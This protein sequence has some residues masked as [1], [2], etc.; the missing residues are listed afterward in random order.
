[1][2]A[3]EFLEGEG[4]ENIILIAAYDSL[5][6]D[7]WKV[8]HLISSS[9]VQHVHSRTCSNILFS[10][11]WLFL[12]L[13]NLGIQSQNP[14]LQQNNFPTCVSLQICNA[15]LCIFENGWVIRI[16]VKNR[17]ILTFMYDSSTGAKWRIIQF[18]IWLLFHMTG[19]QFQHFMAAIFQIVYYAR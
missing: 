17:C 6:S 1:M 18:R 15:V 3:A 4:W 12:T 5:Y 19:C 16:L 7:F 10:S 9:V 2:T 13:C 14:F 11:N 8:F